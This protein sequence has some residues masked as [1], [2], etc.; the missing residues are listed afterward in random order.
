MKF[1]GLI[2][3]VEGHSPANITVQWNLQGLRKSTKD[4]GT[5][6]V[7]DTLSGRLNLSENRMQ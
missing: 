7:F 1:V 4:L 6:E 3:H 2:E 5:L